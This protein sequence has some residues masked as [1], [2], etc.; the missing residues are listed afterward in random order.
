[1]PNRHIIEMAIRMPP[2][3]EIA[4]PDCFEH[5]QIMLWSNVCHA[6]CRLQRIRLII[7]FCYEYL[8]NAEIHSLFLRIS[9]SVKWGHTFLFFYFS[10]VWNAQNGLFQ[11]H[12]LRERSSILCP[13]GF[14]P[15][16]GRQIREALDTQI[17]PG[18]PPG[19]N[20][21]SVRFLL[22]RYEIW[23]LWANNSI[24]RSKGW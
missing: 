1:M 17:A 21:K 20:R 3:N 2:P 23:K 8:N 12:A 10:H 5:F 19:P 15:P 16:P 13:L 24:K 14:L 6:C 22:C 11:K 18:L 4:L 7:P 9:G